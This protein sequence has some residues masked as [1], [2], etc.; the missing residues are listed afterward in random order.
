ML[1]A[2]AGSKVECEC[3]GIQKKAC[4]PSMALAQSTKDAIDPLKKK[5]VKLMG[6][7]GSI[8]N[9]HT[10]EHDGNLVVN[11]ETMRP[12]QGFVR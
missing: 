1:R 4:V 2:M 11:L 3:F 5:A 7:P 6:Q 9:I 10:V 8:G 12:G